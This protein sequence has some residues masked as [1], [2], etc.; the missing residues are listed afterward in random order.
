MSPV[1]ATLMMIMIALVGAIG[2]WAWTGGL[3]WREHPQAVGFFARPDACHPRLVVTSVASPVDI[4][5]VKIQPADDGGHYA[6]LFNGRVASDEPWVGRPPSDFLAG[7]STIDL[8]AEEGRVFSFVDASGGN[9][10]AQIRA[11]RPPDDAGAPSATLDGAATIVAPAAQL[12][13]AATDAGCSGIAKVTVRLTDATT[14]DVHELSPTLASPGATT[15]AWT[16]SLATVP[17]VDGR[18]YTVTLSAADMAGNGA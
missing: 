13:G 15:T 4:T 16:A 2:L 1:V 18:S 14:G 3:P 7:G 8:W 9:L 12:T 17:L 6:I 5:N 10:L 11:P